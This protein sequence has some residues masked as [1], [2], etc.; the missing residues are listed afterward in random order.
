MRRQ[1]RARDQ[2]T[3]SDRNEQQVQ[4]SD[5]LEQLDRRRALP[6]DDVRM[7][8]R[9][10]QRKP[11]L[12][13]QPRRERVTI[14]VQRVV[15]NDPC[16]ITTRGL[17]LGRRAKLDDVVAGSSMRAP[18]EPPSVL[19]TNTRSRG[20]TDRHRA[21]DGVVAPRNLKAPIRCR[22]SHLR[23]RGARALTNVR[24]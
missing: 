2:A 6:R 9:R 16:A 22:F 5:F 23:N 12:S 17:E 18:T 11:T 7:V 4:W 24:S 1:R 3:P 8:E 15:E 21:G 14:L 19:Q 20:R 10:D 13:R